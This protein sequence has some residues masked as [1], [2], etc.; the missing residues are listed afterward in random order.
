V[1]VGLLWLEGRGDKWIGRWEGVVAGA[2]EVKEGLAIGEE[3]G[4]KTIR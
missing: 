2:E 1:E 4:W 3:Y